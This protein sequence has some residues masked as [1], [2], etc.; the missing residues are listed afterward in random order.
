[1]TV[2]SFVPSTV[3][4]EEVVMKEEKAPADSE[5]RCPDLCCEACVGKIIYIK[6]LQCDYYD[7]SVEADSLQ[8]CPNP[9]SDS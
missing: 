2:C 6:F 9:G 8:F 3:I 1:M 4:A 5:G 7:E